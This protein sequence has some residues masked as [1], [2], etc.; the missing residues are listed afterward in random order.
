[1]IFQ[2][3]EISIYLVHPAINSTLR[4]IK[5]FQIAIL[6]KNLNKP[7]ASNKDHYLILEKLKIWTVKKFNIRGMFLMD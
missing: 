3:P 7:S 5:F 6:I 4:N 1:M 2:T